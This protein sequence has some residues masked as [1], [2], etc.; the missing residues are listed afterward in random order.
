MRVHEPGL[1]IAY[2]SRYNTIPG[3][4]IEK[5]TAL[6]K[7]LEIGAFVEGVHYK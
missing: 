4:G 7:V 2:T 1:H 3:R 5:N 6:R